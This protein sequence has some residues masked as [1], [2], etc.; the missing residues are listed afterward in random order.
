MRTF[1]ALL[2]LAW[3]PSAPQAQE[4]T[5]FRGPNGDGLSN[6]SFPTQ[7][8]EKDYKW[9]ADLPGE[10][11]SSP[12]I[13]DNRLFL[14][15]ADADAGQRYL[16]CLDTANG[17]ILW[18]KSFPFAKYKKQRNNTFASN[19]PACD[20][21]RVYVLFQGPKKSPLAAFDHQGNKVWEIDLGPYKHG[22][23]GAV[24][25]IVYQD[26]VIVAND[27]KGGSFLL[28]VDS[29][30]G[31]QKWKIPREGKR[32][33]YSTPCI[34]SPQGRGTEVIFTH[35]FEGVIGVDV[36]SG[37]T[38]WHIDPFGRFKQRAIAS[39]VL[40]D[41]LIIASSGFTTG[42]K[43]LIAIKLSSNGGKVQATEAYRLTKS[44]PHIPTSQVYKGRLYLWSDTGI[45]TC[46]DVKTGKQI[47][48]GRV[49][50]SAFFGSPV[51]ADGRMYAID[52]QG[53]VVIVATGDQFK[54]LGRIPLGESSQATPAI[55]GGLMFLRTASRLF[56]LTKK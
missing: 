29:K 34:H 55:S 13:W 2:F 3:I 48:I 28:A 42:R 39:P 25:P 31:N 12:V 18:K 41:D 33:C 15:S 26:L 38:N 24:S 10:G 51:C 37:K 40:A 46:S 22:Q 16:L 53:N 30:T 56:A 14:T 52:K 8:T 9:K 43:N 45:V 6:T 23:G 32:A 11:G 50:G 47:W 54:L 21:D 20:R 27:H 7:W 1:I 36:K 4:W 17:K 5:R 19:T 35:S 44:V 49:P